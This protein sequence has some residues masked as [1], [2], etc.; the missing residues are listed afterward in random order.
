MEKPM[1]LEVAVISVKTNAQAEF[2]RDFP[3][4]EI[5]LASAKGYISHK[6]QRSLDRAGTYILLVQWRTKE[7]HTVGFCESDLFTQFVA[8]LS[9]Y[10]SSEP[11]VEHFEA[12]S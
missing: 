8:L 2:E 3:R 1:I 4:A 6:I 7:D 9:L 12:W 11:R 5:L 10:F